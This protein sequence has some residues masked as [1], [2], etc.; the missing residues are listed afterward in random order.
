VPVHDTETTTAV[1][2]RE[3]VLGMV[4]D[5]GRIDAGELYDVAEIS[6]FTYHQVRLCLARLVDEGLLDQEGR[7]RRATFTATAAGHRTIDPEADF[8]RLAWAQDAGLAG[9]DGAW[10]LVGFALGEDHR[11]ARNTFR[12]HLVAVLGGGNLLPG[13]YVSAHQ[14]EPLVLPVAV[15][16]GIADRIVV[17]ETRE[18]TVGA[19]CDPP[20]VARRL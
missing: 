4:G 2:T 19:A 7:G 14:W 18:L 12:D 17:A 20:A 5:D 8:L 6:G 11:D 9:W 3:L 16:L 10:H 1:T 13:L 15:E